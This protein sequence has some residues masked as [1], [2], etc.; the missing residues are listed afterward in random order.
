MSTDR[1]LGDPV[2]DR[3]MKVVL[4]LS[5]ELYVLRDRMGTI[6][7]LLDEKKVITRSD[8]DD[9][10]PDPQTQSQILGERVFSPLSDTG[11]PERS[12]DD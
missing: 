9:Y 10:M 3:M 1:F 4:A 6:E 12:V 2:R 11:D 5:Q 7:R 8:I